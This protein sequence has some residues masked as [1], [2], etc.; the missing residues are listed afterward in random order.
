MPYPRK[1]TNEQRARLRRVALA[2]RQCA[3]ISKALPTN[4]SL[5][6]EMNVSRGAIEQI[7]AQEL[8]AH[9]AAVPT[10]AHLP[11]QGA[12]CPKCST[13]PASSAAP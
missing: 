8:A 3:E 12:W 9:D 7:L 10:C 5:A 1:V 6:L 2:R 4:K 13:E 11:S